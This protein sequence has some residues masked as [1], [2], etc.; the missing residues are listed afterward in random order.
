V[1]IL[2][3]IKNLNLLVILVKLYP[4]VKAAVE[5]V[6]RE[7]S[8]SDHEWTDQEKK[9]FAIRV[10]YLA[11]DDAKLNIPKSISESIPDLIEIVWHMIV[12]RNLKVKG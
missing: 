7:T 4:I 5:E 12:K 11:I 8:D 6:A 1:N 10:I 9:A 3:W 2:S